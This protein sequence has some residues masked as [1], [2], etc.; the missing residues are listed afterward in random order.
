[1]FKH[2][3]T[4]QWK[5]FFRA[6]SLKSSIAIKILMGFAAVYM[7]AIFIGMGVGAYFVI[8]D[9][10]IGD[11]FDV[12]N[13]FIIYYLIVDLVFRYMLQKMPVTNIKPLLY[14][15]FKKSQVVNFSL[16]KT[17]VSYFNWSHAFFFIPL[18]I[19]LL[20]KGYSATGIIGWHLALI[21]IIYCNNFINVLVNNKDNI[22][23]PLVGLIALLG[24]FQ[25]LQWFDITTYTAPFF[26]ALYTLP[27]ISIIL[28]LLTFGLYYA[29]F[30][31]FKKNLYLDAGL[32][33]KQT[34]AK[35]E[36][37]SWLN[38][39]GNLGT[40][41]KNDIKLIKRNKRSKM[42]V[43]T[44]FFF[45]F[46]GFLFFT[47]TIEAYDGPIWR[48]FAGIFISG[49]FLFSFGQFVPSWD[50]S[51]YPLMMSQNIKYKEYLN[52][53]WYLMVIATIIST[54]IASFYLYFGLD[55]YLAVLVGAIYNIGV[56][57]YVVLLGGAYTRTP[58][59]LTS[60]KKA[61]GDKQS[62]NLKTVMLTMP[63]LLLPLI[64]YGIGHYLISPTAGYIFVAMAGVLGFAFK[65]FVFKKI[66]KIYKKEKYKTLLAYKQ[67]S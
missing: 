8:E 33:T 17:I 59:D 57:S 66:E 21:A 47:G 2:F 43:I 20:T 44:S 28:W 9:M 61:F 48:I 6:A 22:F 35:T 38:R 37:L 26:N 40:F 42:A 29:A 60:A 63:K 27:W 19:V 56:N 14:L 45:I 54:I 11:P 15:P 58:I 65:G 30:N 1:M 53:K 49:G 7:T 18:S 24:L 32:Q 13:K 52:S 51:Y 64:I 34:I 5:S 67:V 3:I 10:N 23:Y 36:D 41:L 39:F 12:I 50:S 31:Y 4:L 25:Y 46:Y 55:A 62:F 16:A